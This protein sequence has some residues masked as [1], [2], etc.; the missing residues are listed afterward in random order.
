MSPEAVKGV[1]AYDSALARIGRMLEARRAPSEEKC[2]IIVDID[3][4]VDQAGEEEENEG[5]KK[6]G[7]S[8][9]RGRPGSLEI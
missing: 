3:Q 1:E 7:V 4:E 6:E 2:N 9:A 5:V 8:T